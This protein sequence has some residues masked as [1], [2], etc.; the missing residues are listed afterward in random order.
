M[1]NVVVLESLA[2]RV[3][4][5]P[6]ES[7]IQLLT[8]PTLLNFRKLG[9]GAEELHIHALVLVHTALFVEQLALH[10]MRDLEVLLV[11]LLSRK[12]NL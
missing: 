1:A 12:F 2:L 10:L 8:T 11:L 3:R 5:H 7:L 4:F 6:Q 9:D